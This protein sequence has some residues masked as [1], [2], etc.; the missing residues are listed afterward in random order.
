MPQERRAPR[1]SASN[2]PSFLNFLKRPAPAGRF[3]SSSGLRDQGW[4]C[5][6]GL[7]Y[8]L[9]VPT[10]HVNGVDLAYDVIGSGEPLF[11]LNGVMMTMTTWG[12]QTRVLSESYTCVLHDFRGQL[13]SSKP[14]GP[15]SLSMHAADVVALMDHLE[16]ES[17]HLIG[18][19]YGGE[20]AMQA[21]VEY[22]SRVRSLTIIASVSEVDDALRA[23]IERWIV[24]A[25]TD[26]DAL[27]DATAPDNFSPAFLEA[28]SEFV[29]AGRERL[30]GFDDDWF[31]ALADL[32]RSFEGLDLTPRLHEIRCPSLVIVGSE[33][34]LKPVRCSE[35]IA[36]GIPGASLH[37]VEGAGHAVVIEQPDAVNGAILRFLSSV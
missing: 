13:Q 10:V 17:A 29:T 9:A 4:R 3:C 5:V 16:I 1:A 27:Y 14:P 22:P 25:T 7:R 18:T 30:R 34:I 36:A 20:V 23:K 12:L 19:S 28:H 26:R 37:V 33:D 35:V 31:R 24:V 6:R 8:D 21:A 15:Y 32:C 2:L 11:L